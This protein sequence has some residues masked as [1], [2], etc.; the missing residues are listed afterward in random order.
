MALEASKFRQAVIENSLRSW[1]LFMGLPTADIEAIGSF[2]VSK[3][4]DKGK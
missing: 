2:V 3:H 4:L 1:Q